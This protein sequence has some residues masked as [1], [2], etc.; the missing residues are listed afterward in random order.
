[1]FRKDETDKLL[2]LEPLKESLPSKEEL[3]RALASTQESDP[4][5]KED[6]ASRQ[7]EEDENSARYCLDE[8]EPPPPVE[9]NEKPHLR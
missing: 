4:I 8:L 5:S 3:L 7:A 1:M 9:E 2:S 6:A